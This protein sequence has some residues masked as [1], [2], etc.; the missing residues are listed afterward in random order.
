LA[1]YSKLK[2]IKTH[3]MRTI[4]LVLGTAVAISGFV[5]CN[6]SEKE[7]AKQDAAGLTQF[8]DSVATLTPVYTQENWTT[9]DNAYQERAMKAESKLATLEEEDKARAEASKV[10]YAALKDTYVAKIKE[11]EEAAKIPDYR[12]T[13]RAS[14][15][16][17]GKVGN[18]MQFRFVTGNNILSFYQGFVDKIA[19][20]KKNYTREDWDEIKVLYEALDTRKNEVEK[21]LSTSDNMK[22]AGL[23]I[24]FASII[25]THRVTAKL[26]ESAASKE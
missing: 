17:E 11:R 21:D 26:R 1:D 25:A 24:K 13:L 10:K 20:N 14:L 5:A 8:V 6:N 15:F 12:Q 16:G 22:I 19:E 3:I 7:A 18:D 4:Y 23:K 2:H 9:I